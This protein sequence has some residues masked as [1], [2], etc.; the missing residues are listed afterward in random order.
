MSCVT[1]LA[2]IAIAVDTLKNEKIIGNREQLLSIGQIIK[3]EN[4]RMNTQ[5]EQILQAAQLDINQVL[6][7][8]ETT[9]CA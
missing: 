3:A 7:R 1:P 2:T 4:A 8:Q 5:V 9:S 6:K